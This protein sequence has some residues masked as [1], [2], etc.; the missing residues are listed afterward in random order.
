[1]VSRTGKVGIAGFGIV[2]KRRFHFINE[3]SNLVVTAICEQNFNNYEVHLNLPFTYNVTG[4]EYIIPQIRGDDL[5]KEFDKLIESKEAQSLEWQVLT[6]VVGKIIE[7]KFALEQ[8]CKINTLG[9]ADIY[10]QHFIKKINTFRL[11]DCTLSSMCGEL[12]MRKWH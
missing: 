4:E 6:D 2:G 3:N 10:N 9:F 7:N 1:M 5:I 8:M 12:V 11:F